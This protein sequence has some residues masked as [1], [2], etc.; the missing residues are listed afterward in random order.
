[1]QSASQKPE[2]PED[3]ASFYLRQAAMEF[4]QDLDKIRSSADFKD[5][6]VPI[7]VNALRQGQ[8]LFSED[9]KK[10]IMGSRGKLPA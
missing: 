6:S 9:E 1:L 8:S 2:E 5:S 4:H 10:G 3:F 7:L